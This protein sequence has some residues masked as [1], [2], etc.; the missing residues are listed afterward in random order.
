MG[1][2]VTIPGRISS[3]ITLVSAVRTAVA[4][5]AHL[6]FLCLEYR[7]F[8]VMCGEL[9]IEKEDIHE[10]GRTPSKAVFSRPQLQQRPLYC[11]HALRRA[12][13]VRRGVHR[14]KLVLIMLFKEKS[15]FV[16]V[17]TIA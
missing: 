7:A 11:I 3:A 15:E 5:T 2:E 8:N 12:S 1:A 17:Q 6:F 13:S 10:G 9:G 14:D 4:L 16:T